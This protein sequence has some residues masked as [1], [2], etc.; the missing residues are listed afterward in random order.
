MTNAPHR[1]RPPNVDA[2]L[3]AGAASAYMT[4]VILRLLLAMLLLAPA[5]HAQTVLAADAAAEARWIP[6]TLTA[7]N[8]IRFEMTVDGTPAVALL[9]T[10]LNRTAVSKDFARRAK[11]AADARKPTQG[12]ALG[13][14][15]A[16]EWAGTR[17]VTMGALTRTGG[18]VM[19]LELPRLLAAASGKADMLVGSDLIA[20]HALDID[21]AGKRFRL[22]PGGSRPF[23]GRHAPLTVQPGTG[24]YLT[25]AMLGTRRVRPLLIDSGDGG[26]LTVTRTTWRAARVRTAGVTSTTAFGAGGAAVDAG[27]AITDAVRLGDAPTGPIEVRIEPD[28]GFA[29]QARVVGRVGNGLLLRYRVLLDPT[30]GRM[31][32][33]PNA[34][35]PAPP[36]RS[37]SGLLMGYDRN[38]LRVL[39]VMAGSP[40]ARTGWK[41]NDLICAVDGQPVTMTADGGIDVRWGA[42]TPGRIVAL[43]LCDGSER[44]L[45]LAHFY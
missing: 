34:D 4:A 14:T 20:G 1:P 6:F 9:D 8:H 3:C 42:D 44:R 31:I 19:V 36:L 40:A 32:L 2:P 39:H 35:A 12:V 21:F 37:T 11:L 28:G 33:R 16:V 27:L 7:A 22:L 45:T 23:E 41:A 26:A 38:R 30:A 5:A 17:S 15:I 10:G 43:T 24:L 18:S 29:R 13:G 25:E